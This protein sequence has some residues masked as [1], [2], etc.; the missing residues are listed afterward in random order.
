MPTTV[1]QPSFAAGEIT[2]SLYG[3][4]DLAKYQVALR[5]ALNYFIRPYGGAATRAGT[6]FVGECVDSSAKSRLYG[7]Q[8]SQV[9]TYVLEFADLKMRVIKDGGYVLETA[10]AI[11]G[12]TRANPGVV[13]AIGHGFSNGD[14]VWII[15]VGG[16]TQINRRRFTVAGA[17]ANTFQ[18]SGVDTTSYGAWTTG[19][20]VSRF[21]TLTTPYAVADLPLLKFVQSADTLT[22][23]HPT[24]APRNLTRTAHTSWTLTAKTFQ[25]DQAAPTVFST[26]A[27]GVGQG[28]AITAENDTTGEESRPLFG[29]SN[30][31]TSTIGWTGATGASNYNVYR[32]L[33]GIYGFVGR[34]TPAPV[35]FTDASINPDVSRTPPQSNNP[36]GSADNYP[37]CSTYHDGRQ[38]YARTNNG[39][40]TLWATQSASFNNMDTSQPTDDSDAITR[41]IAS[42]K[43]DEIRFLVPLN[44]LLVF[45]SGAVWKAWSGINSD[46]MTPSNVNVKVQ[47]AE[48]AANI[49][50]ISTVSSVLYVTT[51]GRRVRD[52]S[53]D[54]GSDSFGGKDLS[55]LSAHIFEGKTISDWAYAR[56]P[57]GLIWV[58]L[59]DGTMGCLTYLREHDVTAWTR[60]TTSGTVESV[61]AIQES[62][63]TI[64]YMQVARTVGGVTKR[65]V[66]R[67]PSRYFQTVYDAWCVDCGYRYDGWNTNSTQTLSISGATYNA[68][69]TVTMTAAGFTPFTAATVGS[70]YILR[71]G[72][73][74]VTV[75][76]TGYT[77]TTHVTATLSTAPHTSLQ[78]T[79][80]WDWA[81]ATATLDGLWHLEGQ[82]VKVFAD[83]SVMAD[84][85]VASGKITIERAS[86]RILAG[87]SYTCDFETLDLEQG[88]PTPQSRQKRVSE[89]VLRVR[90]ARGLSAGPTSD[91]LDD[92][93]ERTTEE[94]GYPTQLTTGD[95]KITID[96]SWNSNGRIFVRQAYPLPAEILAAIPRLEV[97]E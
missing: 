23:T 44:H 48:G 30:T 41:T 58:V 74:Q 25:P 26:T 75:V 59:S 19:G 39:P 60:A 38:W 37:G 11:T 66:E 54:S 61:A 71:S 90:W 22:I 96:P 73:R 56:D 14:H 63:E 10:T 32:T 79:A 55:I 67:M 49:E 78:A 82:T 76:V 12:V 68:G 34:G 85:T 89:V 83:G 7:F 50:P 69:D 52:L 35:G 31:M 87:L 77:D 5:T 24:Y 1:I 13:T 40:Q 42:R 46:V 95:E 16:M 36:F 15:E 84:Q 8:F 64:L 51:S 53:F 33:N 45:T 80:T 91:R 57:D 27:P 72:Q 47:G 93:K 29:T 62:N 65:Y 4:V 88:Q 3:R 17:T 6:A 81:V 2:P 92:I 97:G 94:M 70:T 18:L 43:V 9:Q 20:T 21:Y 28:Y 86:G